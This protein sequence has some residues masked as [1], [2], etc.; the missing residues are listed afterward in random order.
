[1]IRKIKDLGPI[2]REQFLLYSAYRLTVYT[3]IAKQGGVNAV[4]GK[5]RNDSSK[6]DISN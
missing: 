6:M 4:A 5:F 3:N 1:M 2:Q